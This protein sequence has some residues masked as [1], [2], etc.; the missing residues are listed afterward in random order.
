MDYNYHTHTALC[1]HA[2]GT[3]RE[4]IEKAIASGIRSMGFSDHMPFRFPDGYESHY[5]VPVKE[6]PGYIRM[7]RQ[8]REEYKDRIELFVGFEMEYYPLYFRDM[9][10]YAR[11]LGAEYLVLGVHFLG[12]EHPDG[13]YAGT[14]TDSEALLKEYVDSA[15]EAMDTGA[16]TYL[17]HPD[18]MH[19]VGEEAVYEREMRRLCRGAARR[20]FPLE[21]NLLGIRDN[22]HYPTDRFWK[23]AGEEQ[24]P[25]VLGFDA[26]T[27]ESAGDQEHVPAAMEFV[28]R[29]H[30]NYIGRPK[31]VRI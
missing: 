19:Y 31:I 18:I 22:R 25:V 13:A 11:E 12:N 10:Q 1:G 15:L 24:A 8:L 3:P 4:Y 2:T 5:R 17:A 7:I 26:H 29:H 20:N 27:T 30:L 14:P 9:L 6:A 21:I 23:I 16:F 28:Q